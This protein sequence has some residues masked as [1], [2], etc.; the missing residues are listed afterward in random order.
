VLS[1]REVF[2]PLE[3]VFQLASKQRKSARHWNGQSIMCKTDILNLPNSPVG[4]VLIVDAPKR[5]PE[6]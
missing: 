6:I 4:L 1:P 3:R 5:F 2:D